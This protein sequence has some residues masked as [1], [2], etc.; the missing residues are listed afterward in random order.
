VKRGNAGY[1]RHALAGLDVFLRAFLDVH[2]L[3]FAGFED[4]AALL[5]LDEL[6]IFIAA[7]DLHA[8]VLAGALRARTSLSRG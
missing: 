5:A 8:E 6:R 1:I 7:H 3:E 2:V 4:L